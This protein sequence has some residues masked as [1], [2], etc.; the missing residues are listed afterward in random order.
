MPTAPTT[1]G[2]PLTHAG[3]LCAASST[4]FAGYFSKDIILESAFAANSGV[5][6]YAFWLGIAAAIMTAFYSWRLLF[7][8]FHGAPR[9]DEKVMAHVHESPKVMTIPLILLALGAIFSGYIGVQLGMVDADG[10]FWRGSIVM[11]AKN[12]VLEAAH[13]VPAWVKGLPAE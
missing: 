3:T 9:A 10:E 5:G 1:S 6:F 4:F 8:T 11:F 13:N 12:N 7:L 2:N